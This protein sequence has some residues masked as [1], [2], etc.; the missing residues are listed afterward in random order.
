MVCQWL[1]LNYL[2]GR[3]WVQSLCCD[4]RN[5]RKTLATKNMHK[6]HFE[7]FEELKNIE[8]RVA[9]FLAK[10]C[11]AKKGVRKPMLNRAF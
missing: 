4:A 11:E 5:S 6:M 2:Q 8:N 9:W 10:L 3:I 7:F 1:V